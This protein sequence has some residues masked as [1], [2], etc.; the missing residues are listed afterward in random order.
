LG[1]NKS[2]EWGLFRWKVKFKIYVF[3]KLIKVKLYLI[4]SKL[5][6]DQPWD[7]FGGDDAEAETPVLW[8]PHAKGCLN[9]SFLGLSKDG[10]CQVSLDKFQEQPCI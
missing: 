4:I 1:L 3:T 6:G 8:P 5:E 2:L 7:F 10:E 9:W